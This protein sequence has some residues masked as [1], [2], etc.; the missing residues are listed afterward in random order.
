MK[1]DFDDF[2]LKNYGKSL[3]MKYCVDSF[4]EFNDNK[5]I[6]KGKFFFQ[7][8]FQ[9]IWYDRNSMLGFSEKSAHWPNNEFSILTKVFLSPYHL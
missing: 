6:I 1:K 3:K 7:C 9:F 5:L 8:G 2:L 4:L